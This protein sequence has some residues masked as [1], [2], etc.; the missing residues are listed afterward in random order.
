MACS[1]V[2]WL[3]FIIRLLEHLFRFE[4]LQP[5]GE[6][7]KN[8]AQE[9]RVDRGY[10]I[11]QNLAGVQSGWKAKQCN[12]HTQEELHEANVGD[13]KKFGLEAFLRWWAGTWYEVS[14]SDWQ[15]DCLLNM[16]CIPHAKLTTETPDPTS[17]KHDLIF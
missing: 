13:M 16:A 12:W 15:R 2:C 7:G 9:W 14:V 17:E 3:L 5:V 11:T 8:P 4:G 10:D 1:L 6:K